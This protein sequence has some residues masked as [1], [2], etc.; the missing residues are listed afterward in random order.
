MIRTEISEIGNR[1]IKKV[2]KIKSCFLENMDKIV[3]LPARLI[4]KR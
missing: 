2:N 3:K 1:N 4:N